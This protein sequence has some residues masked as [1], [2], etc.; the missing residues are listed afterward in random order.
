MLNAGFSAGYKTL[1]KKVQKTECLISDNPVS[2]LIIDFRSRLFRYIRLVYP[3][4]TAHKRACSVFR[5]IE[6]LSSTDQV[7]T[8]KRRVFM[9]ALDFTG[10]EVEYAGVSCM[11][12]FS[13]RVSCPYKTDIKANRKTK[14][15]ERLKELKSCIA[16]YKK[17]ML[18]LDALEKCAK[19]LESYIMSDLDGV[20]A[21]FYGKE[22]MLNVGWYRVPNEEDFF[23]SDRMCVKLARLQN[24]TVLSEDLDNITLFGCDMMIMEI[25]TKFFVYD[26]FAHVARDAAARGQGR[27]PG[28]QRAAAAAYDPTPPRLA[29][30]SRSAASFA[31]K[32]RAD[33]TIGA[34]IFHDKFGY[35]VVAAQEGNKLEIDFESAG[36]KR[37]IDSFVRLAD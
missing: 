23:E 3:S 12:V 15:D 4:R 1:A 21:A 13:S 33:I 18:R 36:R 10:K 9:A 31:A 30:P 32:P 7:L 24:A 34:R 28:W 37:V 14:T 6:D 25:H 16:V 8:E 20:A 11:Y 5:T 35:G 26:P 2:E 27:G 17:D 29:E 22:W 19:A